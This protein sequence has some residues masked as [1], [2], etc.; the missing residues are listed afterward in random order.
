M[1]LFIREEEV[2]SLLPMADALACVE[3]A[4]RELGEV[5]AGRSPG[6]HDDSEVTLFASQGLAVE[7]VAVGLHVYRRAKAQGAGVEMAL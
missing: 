7:D 6:R 2:L 3:E 1:P 5:V 4:F